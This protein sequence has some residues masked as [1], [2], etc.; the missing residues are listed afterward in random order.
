MDRG[1][2]LPILRRN[3]AFVQSGHIFD[4]LNILN[5]F[6]GSIIGLKPIVDPK[7]LKK[8]IFYDFALDRRASGGRDQKSLKKLFFYDFEARNR[9]LIDFWPQNYF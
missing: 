4:I 2:I 1:F 7:N 8:L 9:F 6:L 5:M 3:E